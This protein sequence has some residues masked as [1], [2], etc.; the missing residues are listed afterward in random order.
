MPTRHLCPTCRIPLTTNRVGS[1][2]IE[3]CAGCRAYWLPLSALERTVEA[4][5]GSR[6]PSGLRF[7]EEHLG[8]G[9]PTT[10]RCPNDGSVLRAAYWGDARMARCDACG[11]IWVAA[12]MLRTIRAHLAAAPKTDADY[13]WTELLDMLPL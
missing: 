8:T 10:A 11:G 2:E 9:P 13:R 5:E 3:T 6:T 12:Y 4:L 7:Q 1:F